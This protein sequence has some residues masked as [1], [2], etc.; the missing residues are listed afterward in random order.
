MA[1][2]I[3]LLNG[4][5]L[6]LLGTREPGVYGSISLTDIESGWGINRPDPG[7]AFRRRGCHRHQ[8]R[9]AH[10]HQRRA[11]R[12]AGCGRH[13]VYRSTYLQYSS[14][15]SVPPSF[16]FVGHRDR[17]HM[18]PRRRRLSPG[19]RVR[20]QKSVSFGI[21]RQNA[22]NCGHLCRDHYTNNVRN[23]IWI[24]ENSRP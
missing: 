16:L 3:L 4:P 22:Y 9:R 10:P 21:C 18:R 2:N 7:R 15:R 23:F 11:A 19:C 14:T 20:T 6:N 12:C 13:P 8:S 24:Y 1:K 17:S 5:N